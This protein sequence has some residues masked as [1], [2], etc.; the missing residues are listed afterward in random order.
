[1]RR[2]IA[3]TLTLAAAAIALLVAPTASAA[4]LATV[5][6]MAKIIDRGAGVI[7]RITVECDEGWQVL[8]ANVTVSQ[9]N[10]AVSGTAG[11]PGVTCDGKAHKYRVQVNAQE[12]S[13][14]KG[15][16]HASAF[17]LVL[18]EGGTTEQGQASGTIKI[19]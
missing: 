4:V 18:N 10:Q 2:R 7:A 8:E 1:M 16:A 13:F 9:D 12:G 14:R 19:H 6:P 3:L 17:V 5:E 15:E 11:I